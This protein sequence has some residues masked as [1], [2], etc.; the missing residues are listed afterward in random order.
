M[1]FVY[2]R[3][4]I[5]FALYKPYGMVARQPFDSA[6]S[7]HNVERALRSKTDRESVYSPTRPSSN[8]AVRLTTLNGASGRAVEVDFKNLG[9]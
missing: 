1:K 2:A 8:V 5:R 3:V 9:F 4:P 7:V 6:V